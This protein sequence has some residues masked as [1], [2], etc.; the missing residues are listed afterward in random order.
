[1]SAL[2][3]FARRRRL[4][5]FFAT[6]VATAIAIPLAFRLALD[7]DVLRLLPQKGPAVQ[8]FRAYLDRFGSLDDLYIVFEAPEDRDISDY[9]AFV[10]A[11][12]RRLR[13]LPEIR[14]VDTKLVEEG[15]NWNYV[16]DREFLLLGAERLPEALEHMTGGGMQREL[17][18]SREL[19]SLPSTAV[20][21]FVQQDPLGL[22]PLLRD[23]LGSGEAALRFDPAREGYMSRDGRSRLII[24]EPA[25]PPFDTD[26]C[27]LLFDRLAGVEAAANLEA[28]AEDAGSDDGPDAP[29][30]IDIVG[31]HRASLEAERLI[32]TEAVAEAL[33][34]M[35][36]VLLLTY[37]VFRNLWIV[38]CAMVPLGLG[39]LFTVAWYGLTREPISAAAT[40][41]A[42]MLFGL[43]IDGIL[44]LYLRHLEEVRAVD[45]AE[46]ATS[47]LSGTARS[48]VLGNVTTAATFYAL[49]VVDFPSLA[50]MGRLVGL[51]ILLACGLTLLLLPGLLAVGPRTQVARTFTTA[52]LFPLVERHSKAILVAIV[53]LTV[54]LG[55]ALP[56]LRINT[57]I[58]RL[59]PQTPAVTMQKEIG[60]RFSLPDDV[61]IVLAEGSDLDS[62]LSMHERLAKAARART[63]PVSMNSAADLLPPL[64]EQERVAAQIRQSGLRTEAVTRELDLAAQTIGFK[65]QI[66]HPFIERLPRLLDAGARLTFQGYLDNG[67][68]SVISR[69]VETSNGEYVVASYLYPRDRAAF[70]DVRVLVEGVLGLRLTGIAAVN[71]EL[72][73][74]FVR[75]FAAGMA[76]GLTAVAILIF[77][78]FRTVG[79]TVLALL[80]TVL[81]LIWSAGLLAWLDVELDLFSFFAVMTFLGIGVDYGV[82]LLHR[83]V[84]ESGRNLGQV[85]TMTGPAI[86]LAVGSTVISYGTLLGSSYGPLRS[87]GIMS[88]TTTVSCAVATLL[89][90]PAILATGGRRGTA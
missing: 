36:G 5:L 22:L 84:R 73:G 50:Q 40:G 37:A 70:A 41:F 80:P 42:A 55:A 13:S 52:W 47:R 89:V 83:Y 78:V 43:G 45:S 71:D 65:P 62:L 12:V 68:D 56:R 58:D 88:V 29:P 17:A 23:R 28:R 21:G 57:R 39:A 79:M 85:L 7:P 1:M 60:A 67:L 53:V 18:R 46:E 26:F 74:R 34:S 48:V 8:D 10:A 32:R 31:A 27:K 3:L 76:I 77:L 54:G 15:Q 24:A 63:N 30:R 64:A 87:L 44:L 90:L 19:L 86:L 66:F 49:S 81:G 61:A 51:S 20:K 16:L 35:A 82:H 4:A 59:Q 11:Y 6:L 14:H 2:L 69:F 38:V 33:G 72:Q 25:R 75:Q 9:Q